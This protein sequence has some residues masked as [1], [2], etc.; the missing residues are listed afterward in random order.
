VMVFQRG[1]IVVP[2]GEVGPRVNLVSSITETPILNI[3]QSTAQL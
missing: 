2:D 3:E 1:N